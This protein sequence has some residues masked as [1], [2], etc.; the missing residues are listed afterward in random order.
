MNARGLAGIW[1]GGVR[2]LVGMIHLPALPGAPGFAGSM[3]R[4][5]ERATK[6]ARSLDEAGFDGL[7]VENYGDVPF[8]RGCVPSETVAAIT[9]AVVA[10]RGASMLPVGVNVLRNDPVS[11]V[12]IAAATGA[13]FVRA[14]VHTGSM[15]TDQGLIEGRAA[16]TM[17]TRAALGCDVAVLADIHVKHATP[18]VGARI[19]DAADDTWHRGRADALIVSGSS[20]GTE[21][22]PDAVRAVRARVP[23]AAILV[24][25]GTT[26]ENVRVVLSMADGAIVGSALMVDGRAGAGVDPTRARTLIDVARG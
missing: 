5:L 23:E 2:P 15:W 1:G 3:E 14:N 22:D 21:T 6:D 17:R 19:E 9:A 20:T 11:A 24:G 25:S 10:I 4:V 12:G 18:P 16:E 26:V 13:R 8:F 7:L